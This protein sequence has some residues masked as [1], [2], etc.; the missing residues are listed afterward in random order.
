[1]EGCCL[2]R[3]IKEVNIN[4]FYDNGGG[5]VHKYKHTKREFHLYLSNSKL[6]NAATNTA[7]LYK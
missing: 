4:V 2:S 6:Q 5:Y 7:Y 1:M 3:F